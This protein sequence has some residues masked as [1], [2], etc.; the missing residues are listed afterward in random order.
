MSVVFDLHKT[1]PAPSDIV[2]HV[3]TPWPNS[4]WEVGYH[5][6]QGWIHAAGLALSLSFP[7]SVIHTPSHHGARLT[8]AS[9]H[10]TTTC[11]RNFIRRNKTLTSPQIP[12]QPYRTPKKALCDH[13]ETHVHT[14]PQHTIHT[15]VYRDEV[16]SPSDR[17]DFLNAA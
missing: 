11:A 2:L 14:I 8:S 5:M 6:Q 15:P 17:S 4:P 7:S 16:S 1:C 13:S 12:H 9:I 10:A 3:R